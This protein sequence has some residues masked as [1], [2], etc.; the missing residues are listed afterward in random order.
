MRSSR[1]VSRAGVAVLAGL[2]LGACFPLPSRTAVESA[3]RRSLRADPEPLPANRRSLPAGATFDVRL[4]APLD[5][6][7][8]RPGDRFTAT[9]PVAVVARNGEIVVPVGA[10]L[11][12]RVRSVDGTTLRLDAERLSFGKRSY[13]LMAAL[14]WQ[15]PT[16]PGVQQAGAPSGATLAVGS[17]LT[18][19]VAQ[20]V[21]LR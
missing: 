9:L 11:E 12:G 13:P 3:G 21:A 20:R 10:R 17:L 18:V 2:T 5:H 6:R 4:D 7:T 19:R 1:L 16:A 8:S 15:R 14:T